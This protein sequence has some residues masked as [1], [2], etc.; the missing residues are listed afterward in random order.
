LTLSILTPAL[1]PTLAKLHRDF[2]PS[3]GEEVRKYEEDYVP[4][5]F[6]GER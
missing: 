1:F 3:K 2:Q 5:S 6:K 4:S